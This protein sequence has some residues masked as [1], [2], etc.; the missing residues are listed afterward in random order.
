[1]RTLETV[2]I[3][4]TQ[5]NTDRQT[6]SSASEP[7]TIGSFT[8][9]TRIRFSCKKRFLATRVDSTDTAR[10]VLWSSTVDVLKLFS[11]LKPAGEARLFLAMFYICSVPCYSV[12]HILWFLYMGSKQHSRNLCRCHY[13]YFRLCLSF[14]YITICILVYTLL[15]YIVI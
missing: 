7:S 14:F 12:I 13:I 2:W 1:M 10:H 11:T 3:I 15:A 5:R 4:I 6:E 8:L 9:K